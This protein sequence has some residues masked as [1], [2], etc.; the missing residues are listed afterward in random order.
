M[1]HGGHMGGMTLAAGFFSIFLLFVFIG[2]DAIA[3]FS[4]PLGGWSLET[5][6]H[7][8]ESPS[9]S[10]PGY[11]RLGRPTIEM[12]TAHSTSYRD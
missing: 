10:P 2:T 3:P 11:A 9:H 8:M 12:H 4:S 6:Y 1:D 7:L 5:A